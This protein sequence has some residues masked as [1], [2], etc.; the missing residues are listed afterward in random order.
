MSV[1]TINVGVVKL[2]AIASA[3]LLDL[4]LDERAERDDINVRAF[5]S[6]A[7]MDEE[8]ST[9]P[10]KSVIAWAPHFV[11]V[12]SPN[13]ALPGPTKVREMLAKAKL[14]TITISDGPAEKAFYKKDDQGKKHV[15]VLEGQ[16]FIVIPADSMIGA[17]KEFL[18]P[19]EMSLF[20]S[21]AIKVLSITGVVRAIQH[22]LDTVI[23]ALQEG[24][25][26]EMP[27]VK[28]T[29]E[30]IVNCGYFKNPYAKA[31]AIAALTISEA[32][33]DIT[34]RGCFKTKEAE[35]YIPLVAAGHEMMRVAGKLA[36]E[37]RELEKTEDSVLRNP[38][39]SK[40]RVKTKTALMEKPK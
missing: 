9:G 17:K 6:G 11:L 22:E 14:P 33:A 1:T 23:T 13:A 27:K 32:V 40:G 34:A 31:K 38:H 8:S 24:K 35:N 12:V 5:T 4:I 10:V 7:K 2:G 16:G 28:L 15:D 21:D 3:P 36:D 39:V 30:K 19:T 25:T 20:N 18:D 29:V 37:V 26:P